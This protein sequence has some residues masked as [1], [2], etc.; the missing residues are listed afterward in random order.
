MTIAFE[1]A[2]TTTWEYL[3]GVQNVVLVA[4]VDGTPRAVIE[5]CPRAGFRLTD[6][7]DGSI[8]T[9]LSLE[10]AKREYE[11]RR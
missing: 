1:G 3:Q 5:L 11:S 9:F 8:Q 7:R 2:T 6:C 4:R 10:E